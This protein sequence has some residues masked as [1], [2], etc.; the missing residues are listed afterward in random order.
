[1]LGCWILLS[2]LFH[3]ASQVAPLSVLWGV[4]VQRGSLF[5]PSLTT[6][7]SFPWKM[8]E[9]TNWSINPICLSSLFN[10]LVQIKLY[11]DF[12]QDKIIFFLYTW[13]KISCVGITWVC[14]IVSKDVDKCTKYVP[15]TDI[16]HSPWALP[17]KYL[18]SFTR[19]MLV[20]SRTS[21]R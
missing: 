21:K 15:N 9:L 5:Q 2:S 13:V 11:M 10:S 7:R 6:W 19:P 17:G 3:F 14:F 1:M 18:C 16:W 8:K 20:T 4:A 12:V